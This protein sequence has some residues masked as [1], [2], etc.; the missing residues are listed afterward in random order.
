[1]F[2]LDTRTKKVTA[3]ENKRLIYKKSLSSYYTV[4]P[5]CRYENPDSDYNRKFSGL[6]YANEPLN[7]CPSCGRQY[8]DEDLEII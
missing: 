4:C 6:P 3:V 1:M 7:V 5:Y 8:N 2:Q